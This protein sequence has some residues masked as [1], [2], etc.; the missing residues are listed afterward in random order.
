MLLVQEILFYSPDIRGYLQETQQIN[1]MSPGSTLFRSKTYALT[2]LQKYKIPLS[3]FHDVDISYLSI[4]LLAQILIERRFFSFLKKK[5]L[6]FSC[7][8]KRR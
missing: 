3:I 5:T 6:F 8:P 7:E 4:F 2:L 1:C